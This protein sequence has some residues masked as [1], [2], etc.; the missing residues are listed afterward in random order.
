M[1]V[2]LALEEI[3]QLFQE[4][5]Q[6]V[7][8]KLLI[9]LQKLRVIK[10][11]GFDNIRYISSEYLGKWQPL[12]AVG[13]KKRLEPRFWYN[14]DGT[15]NNVIYTAA[16]HSIIGILIQRP[17]ID[18]KHL[19]EKLHLV[20][21]RVDLEVLL[22]DLVNMKIIDRQYVPKHQRSTGLFDGLFI[23]SP[24]IGFDCCFVPLPDWVNKL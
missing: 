24:N 15:I 16:C 22:Q 8:H 10:L 9:K 2:G 20:F 21:G 1:D 11:V 4:I 7:L 5:D 3:L 13:S 19:F 14:L 12:S 18:V 23:P 6:I 17:G